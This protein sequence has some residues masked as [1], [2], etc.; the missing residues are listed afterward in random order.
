[1]D[2]ARVYSLPPDPPP[3]YLAALGRKA[4]QLAGRISDGLISISPS[5]DVRAFNESGGASKPRLGELLVCCAETRERAM[6]PVMCQWPIPALPPVILTELATPS[7][8]SQA[9]QSVSQDALKGS[10]VLGSDPAEHIP[11]D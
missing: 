10:V 3:I 4:A 1:M 2:R 5:A 11:G 9:A 6:E 7:Q 8:F